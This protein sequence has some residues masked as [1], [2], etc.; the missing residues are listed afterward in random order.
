M[1]I[2]KVGLPF[3][4]MSSL[5]L[6][7]SPLANA[8][9]MSNMDHSSMDMS[10][11]DHSGMDMSGD[12]SDMDHSGMDVSGDMSDMDHSSMDMSSMDHSGMDMS[13]MDHSSMDMSGMDHSSMDMSEMDMS[14]MQGGEPPP[15]ARSPDYSNGVPYGQYGKPLMMGSLPLWGVVVDDLGYQFEEDLINFEAEGWYGTDSNRVRLRTEGSAQTKDDKD[16]ESLSSLAYWKPLGI[17][18]NGEVGAAYD[19]QNDNAA[20]MAGI[21]GTIPYF[22]ETDARAYL[23]TDGQVR[24]D[25]SAEY[26]WRL[27]QRWVVIPEVELTAFSKDDI[28]NG[29]TKGFNEF[30]AEVRL[31]YETLSRQLAPYVGLSYESALGDARD[32]RRQENEAVDSSSLTAGVTFWF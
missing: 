3:I 4:G 15:N 21:V 31:A 17:F 5:I 1:K 13:G 25:L 19:T 32:L 24:L 16:I 26:E 2:Y 12:M 30:G 8:A 27:E 6:L 29:M 10:S 14:G 11:M 7:L 23:Y 20:V 18:W 22:I 9:E 28:D